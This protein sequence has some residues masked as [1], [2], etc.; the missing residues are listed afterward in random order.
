VYCNRRANSIET[1]NY[2]EHSKSAN[3]LQSLSCT[4]MLAGFP[5]LV[6]SIAYV[7]AFLAV[8]KKVKIKNKFLIQIQ[9]TP[10]RQSM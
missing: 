4:L 2:G 6:N 3:I 5:T 9:V 7:Q 10:K 8:I 1:R